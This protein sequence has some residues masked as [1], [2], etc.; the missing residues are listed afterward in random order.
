MPTP[1]RRRKLY[2]GKTEPY[3]KVRQGYKVTRNHRLVAE[4]KLGRPLEEGEVV[5]HVKGK[6]DI[7]E[8][9]QVYKSHRQ[10]MF[11]EHY[12]RREEKGI[13]HLFSLEEVLEIMPD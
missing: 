13:Q 9:L 12:Q 10:H 1:E 8:N 7:P 11:A 5:H 3:K 6:E 2:G 4:E